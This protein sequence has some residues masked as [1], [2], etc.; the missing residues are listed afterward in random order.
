MSYR[1]DT[2]IDV[3]RFFTGSELFV[4]KEIEVFEV[5]D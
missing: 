5:V 2:G 1:N 4:V 3:E